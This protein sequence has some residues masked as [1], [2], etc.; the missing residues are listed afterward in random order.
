MPTVPLD[1]LH[2]SALRPAVPLPWPTPRAVALARA[3]GFV[4]PVTARPLPGTTPPRYE[5][6]AG[7]KH[8]LLAQRAELSTV[9][10]QVVEDLSDADARRLVELDA[11]QTR[12][13]PLTEARAIQ[14]EVARGRSIAA[15]GRAMGLSRTEASHRLRLLRLAP[16]VQQQVATG[17][18]ELGKA[19]ALV[20]L[21]E[22]A[23][24][25]L[26]Q[27]IAWEGLTTRQVEA[28]AKA[29][30]QGHDPA[31]AGTGITPAPPTR[32]PDLARLETDLAE[33]LGTPVTIRHGADGRGQL[34]VDFANLEILEGMLERIGYRP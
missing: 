20:G 21:S 22:R 8:W 1:L 26:A 33:Q 6:L 25:D 7:L 11:D 18:L 10:V 34:I 4:E 19:R 17:A 23:Q 30:K 29:G 31:R 32:D 3:V 5:I 24:L 16:S 27:R 15:V 2:V 12:Y 14:T 28:L 13:D 9:P